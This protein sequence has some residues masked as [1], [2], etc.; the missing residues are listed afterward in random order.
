MQVESEE[1]VKLKEEEVG[2]VGVSLSTSGLVFANGENVYNY[3][4]NLNYGDV[5]GIGI[6]KESEKFNERRAWISKNGVLL[7]FPPFDEMDKWLATVE[8]SAEEREKFNVG[9]DKEKTEEVNADAEAADKA[10]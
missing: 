7:N 1:K 8:I 3:N 5:I 9:K 10:A 4:W 2:T 6:T